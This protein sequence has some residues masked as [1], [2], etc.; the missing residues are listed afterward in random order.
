M[1]RQRL[2]EFIQGT[3]LEL[4]LSPF[5]TVCVSVCVCVFVHTCALVLPPRSHLA[6]QSAS[7]NV[8]PRRRH[9]AATV[10]GVAAL[11]TRVCT[12]VYVWVCVAAL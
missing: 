4:P 1:E 10:H 3:E 5:S 7:P 6:L 9:L 2:S 12:A 8:R 11:C